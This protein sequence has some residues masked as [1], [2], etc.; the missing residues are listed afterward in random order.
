MEKTGHWPQTMPMVHS[1][2][3]AGKFY[4]ERVIA[5]RFL[6][7]HVERA[8]AALQHATDTA[9]YSRRLR[10]CRDVAMGVCD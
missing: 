1:A 5:R 7:S 8:Q 10:D 3:P 9:Y 2:N 4:M 6:G